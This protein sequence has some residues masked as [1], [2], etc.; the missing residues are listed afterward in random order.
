VPI[1]MKSGSFNLLQASG[2]VQA[3]TGIVLPLI[4]SH[5]M[6]LKYAQV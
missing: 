1:V 6:V 5:G 2:P 4:C 3:Y